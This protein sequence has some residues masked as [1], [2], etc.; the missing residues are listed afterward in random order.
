MVSSDQQLGLSCFTSHLSNKGL[1]RMLQGLAAVILVFLLGACGG[2]DS[3]SGTVNISIDPQQ[4]TLAPGA[5]QS[6]T[7]TVTTDS[8]DYRVAWEA[9]GGIVNDPANHTIT[10]TAPTEEGVYS[11]TV[12][13]EADTSKQ[14]TA[15]ITVTSEPDSGGPSI[16]LQVIPAAVTFTEKGQSK[17]LE[18][19]AYN[20]QGE[21][22][23]LPSDIEWH[24]SHPDRASITRDP[25]IPSR[26]T[27]TSE[28]E[29]GGALI[30]A[31]SAAQTDIVSPP[32]DVVVAQLKPEV[33]LIPDSRVVFPPANLPPDAALDTY[34]PPDIEER[35]GQVFIGSFSEDELANLF[36]IVDEVT[37]RTP[38]VL[39]GEAPAVGAMVLAEEGAAI[40]G[41]V[42]SLQAREGF[43]LLQVEQTL[44]DE[45]FKAYSFDVDI[46]SLTQQGLLVLQ[47]DTPETLSPLSSRLDCE[48]AE[49]LSG[50]KF[51]N[52]NPKVK[53]DPF[54]T[55][56]L[57]EMLGPTIPTIPIRSSFL[58]GANVK[59]SADVKVD[60]QAGAKADAK[61]KVGP[62]LKFNLPV[63]G[64]LSLI[65][66]GGIKVQPGFDIKVEGV[67]GP[68][69]QYEKTFASDLLMQ[70]GGEWTGTGFKDLSE[71]TAKPVDTPAAKVIV[72]K[73]LDDVKLEASYGIYATTTP[74]IQIGGLTV[75]ATCKFLKL[76]VVQRRCQALK[77][78]L[79]LDVINSKLGLSDSLV[80]ESAKR[81][82]NNKDSTSGKH[83]A[84]VGDAK[85]QSNNLNKILKKLK[86]PTASFK[87]GSFNTVLESNYRVFK[88]DSI[89][90][91]TPEFTGTVTDDQDLKVKVGDKVSFTVKGKYPPAVSAR[92][93]SPLHMG[94]VWLSPTEQLK[95]ATVSASGD[96]SKVEVTVTQKMCDDG[97]TLHFLGYNKM[98]GLVETAGYLGNVKLNCG[99]KGEYIGHF[100][101]EYILIVRAE[102]LASQFD[103]SSGGSRIGPYTKNQEWRE[104]A[105]ATIEFVQGPYGFEPLSFY[106][107]AYSFTNREKKEVPLSGSW[108]HDT[109]FYPDG[110]LSSGS[111]HQGPPQ[112]FRTGFHGTMKGLSTQTQ[113]GET[114]V[115]SELSR[116]QWQSVNFAWDGSM[117]GSMIGD[118]ETYEGC[119]IEDE[120]EIC[121][122]LVRKEEWRWQITKK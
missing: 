86:L 70:V 101:Y 113:C 24:S 118:E 3:P 42:V 112:E 56:F 65:V 27:V 74:G 17:V 54:L 107:T 66:S 49:G 88:R 50:I 44:L 11:L 110:E 115:T 9:T 79:Y 98:L 55:V 18:V 4:V 22:V 25:S 37:L 59:L 80:W 85:L 12:T 108:D 45:V 8:S 13:S 72:E 77:D 32:V 7:A 75:D 92:D 95:E 78:V 106:D 103:C 122:S 94:E 119:Y 81:V 36:E 97:A 60:V 114:F 61:C 102:G 19:K 117:S 47:P 87:L 41:R 69:F 63:F 90:A 5:S 14:A 28:T 26:V 62:E 40:L 46:Q 20:E 31:R 116:E 84:G 83:I 23:A 91:V 21:E 99:E 35:N 100:E 89:R 16:T 76:K 30:I 111:W 93:D 51:G 67:A 58:V 96:T 73:A 105:S 29:L 120:L 6:F 43:V 64:K 52:L 104:V 34:L 68:R 48:G 71:A 33:Q 38:V 121:E 2:K 39:R 82:L 10:Y 57:I 15:N 109:E 53:V 1:R